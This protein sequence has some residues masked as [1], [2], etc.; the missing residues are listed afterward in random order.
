[1]SKK[2][3]K[4]LDHCT[5]RSLMQGEALLKG[6]LEFFFKSNKQVGSNKSGW[7]GKNFICVGEKTQRLEI[8]LKINKWVGSN[9]SW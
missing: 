5:L 8:F 1:M 3:L 7:D 9:N 4:K 6:R 2:Y